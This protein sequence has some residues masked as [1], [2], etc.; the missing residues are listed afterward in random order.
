MAMIALDRSV[1]QNKLKLEQ[2]RE[3]K[4]DDRV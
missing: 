2:E 4:I 1:V 3:W